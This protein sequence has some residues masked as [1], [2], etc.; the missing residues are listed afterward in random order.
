ME[1]LEGD[2]IHQTPAIDQKHLG[3]T[4]QRIF[5]SKNPYRILHPIIIFRKWRNAGSV[6][7]ADMTFAMAGRVAAPALGS[8]SLS[9]GRA[10]HRAPCVEAIRSALCACIPPPLRVLYLKNSIFGNN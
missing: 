10:L 1:R 2:N 7:Y 3:S 8:L 5:S 9:V 6:V 4:L